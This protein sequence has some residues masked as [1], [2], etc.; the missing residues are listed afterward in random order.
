MQQAALRIHQVCQ[1]GIHAIKIV[2]QVG[3]FIPA[4]AHAG[5][6]AYSQI[7]LAALGALGV[8]LIPNSEPAVFDADETEAIPLIK[9]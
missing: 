3:Q 4:R 8:Y 6:D 5:A 2:R 1:L 9:G 7:A